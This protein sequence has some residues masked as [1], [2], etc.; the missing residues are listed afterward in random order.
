[1]IGAGD[2]VATGL[3]EGL[4]RPGGNIT[5]LTELSTEHSAKRLELLV[6]LRT[7]KTLGLELAAS[8]VARPTR[9]SNEGVVVRRG[10]HT[11]PAGGAR[12]PGTLAGRHGH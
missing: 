10:R 12:K 11:R 1:M 6:N 9:L 8:L 2:P 7:A 5:G 4:A 3:V